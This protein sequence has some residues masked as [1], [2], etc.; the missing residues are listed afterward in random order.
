MMAD[1]LQARHVS[2]HAGSRLLLDDVNLSLAPGEVVALI[3]PNGAGKS[4]LLRVLTGYQLPDGGSIS[5]AARPLEEWSNEALSRQRAVMR[6]RSGMAFSWRVEEVIA[7]GRAPWP[8]DDTQRV[9]HEVMALTG[10]DSLAGRDFC[11]LSGGE[12]QRVQL[13]RALAQ[14]WH[15]G[16]PHGWLFLDEPTSALD[17]Y[18]QQHILRL[19]RRLALAGTLSVCIVVHDLNLAALWADRIILLHGGRLVAQGSPQQVLNETTLTQWYQAEL[20]VFSHPEH[21]VPQ[22][23]L[24]Q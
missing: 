21:P 23:W 18:H 22:V 5:L 24:Q 1:I 17:L 14:L 6:Q 4:T 15:N 2:L 19:L 16:Q 8:A 11:Q 9:V 13:A 3:G 7:L 10:S 20:K 12:Q